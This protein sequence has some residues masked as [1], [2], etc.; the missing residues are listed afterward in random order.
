MRY[1]PQYKRACP[2]VQAGVARL[3]RNI[4]KADLKKII[5]QLRKSNAIRRQFVPLY[6]ET[7]TKQGTVYCQI[8]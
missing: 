5:H 3:M 2:Y 7:N 1:A 8:L 6:R 4:T